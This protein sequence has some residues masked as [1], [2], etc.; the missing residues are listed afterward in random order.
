MSDFRRIDRVLKGKPTLEGAGVKLKRAFGPQEVPL[1]DPFLLLDDF[2]S[3][4]PHDYIAGFPWHP[5]R[6][7]ETVTYV[8]EGMVEHGD[9]MGNEGVIRWGDVQWMTAGNGIIHQEMPK[10]SNGLMWGFQLWVSLPSLH[11]MDDP[12]YRGITGAEIPEVEVEPGVRIKVICGDV[13]GNEGPVRDLVV[14]CEYLDILME[15]KTVLEHS[16]KKGYKVFAYVVSG[17]GCFDPSKSNST[18]VEQVVIF[19]EGEKVKIRTEDRSLRCLLISGKPIGEPVAWLGP[20]VM[21]TQEE[22]KTAFDEL[23]EGTFLK[24]PKRA[25]KPPK[26][27]SSFYKP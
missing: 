22:L 5:H 14:D 20:I 3:D 23:E 25:R 26:L 9:S 12:R 18:D 2:H 8:L 7:I 11:K 6:G 10:G 1:L 4:N 15:P 17:R 19:K 21:N 13:E 16:T 24:N 27:H